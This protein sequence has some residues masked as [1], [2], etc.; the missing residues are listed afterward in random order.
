MAQTKII[1]FGYIKFNLGCNN[2]ITMIGFRSLGRV[3]IRAQIFI[4]SNRLN[5]TGYHICYIGRLMIY[6]LAPQISE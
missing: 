1:G 3:N 4:F 5:Y 6:C 2:K